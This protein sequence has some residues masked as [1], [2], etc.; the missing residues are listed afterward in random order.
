LEN[1]LNYYQNLPLA[2]DPVIFSIGSFSFHWYSLMYLVAFGA[3]YYL[4]EYRIRKGEYPE[5]AQSVKCKVKNY[6]LKL[7][8]DKNQIYNQSQIQDTKYKIRNTIPRLLIWSF[9]GLLIGAR[10]G[11]VVFYNF[12]HYWQNPLLIISP[13]DPVTGKYI[14]IYGMSYHGG[15]LGALAAAFIYCRKNKINFLKLADFIAPAVPAGYFFGR[16]G[17]FLNG[18][19]YGRATEKFWG[20]RFPVEFPPILRHPSQLY[21]AF[22]EGVLLFF[23]LWSIRNKKYSPGTTLTIYLLSYALARIAAEFFRQPEKD[24]GYLGKFF[25]W[26][27][28][29][30]F[31][32]IVLVVV[33]RACF[34]KYKKMI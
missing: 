7:K 11:E 20:M 17:N 16:L 26:G 2:I 9:I 25:T 19:L 23:I 1:F 33:F 24:I 10:L 31:F 15:L 8:N 4:V 6:N 22:L 27:Q 32:M 21:E 28:I 34:K 13:L 12:S 30:S 5:E 18:E 3:V 14:G 29:L